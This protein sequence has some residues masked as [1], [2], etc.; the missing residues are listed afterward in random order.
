MTCSWGIFVQDVGKR[1][2]FCLFILPCSALTNQR[3]PFPHTRSNS[4]MAP[5][6]RPQALELRSLEP[7]LGTACGLYTFLGIL[8]SLFIAAPVIAYLRRRQENHAVDYIRRAKKAVAELEGK[9]SEL[10]SLQQR[11][12]R[13]V[14]EQERYHTSERQHENELRDERVRLQALQQQ[15][16]DLEQSAQ[17]REAELT[18]AQRDRDTAQEEAREARQSHSTMS[19]AIRNLESEVQTNEEALRLMQQRYNHVDQE[20]RQLMFEMGGS[21]R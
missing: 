3:D 19:Q 1:Q 6:S 13:L 14:Q 17:D 20:Y 4:C 2:F 5:L 10:A 12:D 11:Q 7:P 21:E 15:I 18:V 8:I 16:R 9:T